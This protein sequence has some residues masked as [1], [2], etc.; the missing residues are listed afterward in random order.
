MYEKE[1]T[2]T[3]RHWYEVVVEVAVCMREYAHV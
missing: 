3:D 1:Q 2:E